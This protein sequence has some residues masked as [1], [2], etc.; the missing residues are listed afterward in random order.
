MLHGV[1]ASA[2]SGRAPTSLI[3]NI[4]H[5][6]ADCKATEAGQLT[7]IT[8][9]GRCGPTRWEPA[10]LPGGLFVPGTPESCAKSGTRSTRTAQGSTPPRDS[11]G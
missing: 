7:S 3:C 8:A 4:S 10:P 1:F 11:G 6:I 5:V 9:R 2:S